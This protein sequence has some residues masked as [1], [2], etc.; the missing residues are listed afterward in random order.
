M[1]GER[2]ISEFFNAQGWSICDKDRLS[3]LQTSTSYL[4]RYDARYDDFFAHEY[5]GNVIYAQGTH[6]ALLDT[7][8]MMPIWEG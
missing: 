1:N 3:D 2:E 4:I 5:E 7:E 6:L 8:N